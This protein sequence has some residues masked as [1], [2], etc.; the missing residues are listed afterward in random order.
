GPIPPNASELI[1]NEHLK[2]LLESAKAEYDYVVI[3]TP[4]MGLISDAQVLMKYSDVNLFII[5]NLTKPYNPLTRR[6]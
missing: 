5:S 6:L 4:P 1:L 2:E 3:D